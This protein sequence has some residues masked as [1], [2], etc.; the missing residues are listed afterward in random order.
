MNSEYIFY[1]FQS[2]TNHINEYF[3]NSHLHTNLLTFINSQIVQDYISISYDPNL[4]GGTHFN[5]DFSFHCSHFV[6]MIVN[7]NIYDDNIKEIIERNSVDVQNNFANQIRS[8][9]KSS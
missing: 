3:V 1:T 7:N 4:N 9:E 8:R 6:E 5:L 2:I